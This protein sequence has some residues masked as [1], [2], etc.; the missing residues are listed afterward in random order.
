MSWILNY[1]TLGGTLV[2]GGV[3]A[4]F[5]WPA[6]LAFLS[7]PLGRKVAAIAIAVFSLLLLLTKVFNAG[8]QKE[9]RD[10]KD[11]SD[12]LDAQRNRRDAEL[13]NATDDQ[14]VDRSRRWLR[15][16]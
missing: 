2:L 8:R 11:N 3:A 16:K 9:L 12:K 15:D 10:L 14:L 7:T 5:F 6:I 13:R 1:W 4:W